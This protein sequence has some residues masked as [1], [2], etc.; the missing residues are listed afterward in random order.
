MAVHKVRLSDLEIET[1]AGALREKA[2]KTPNDEYLAFLARRFEMWGTRLGK[3][4]RPFYSR[5]PV[6]R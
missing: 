5:I 3:R 1:I 2:D 4:K 6:K